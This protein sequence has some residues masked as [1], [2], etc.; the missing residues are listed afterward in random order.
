M[1]KNIID[2]LQIDD[3]LEESYNIQVAKG[4][5]AMPKGFKETYKQ[6]KREQVLKKRLKQWQ[7][8][9]Q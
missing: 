9:E 8:N 1:L 2:L 7:K 3:F 4:L 6:K 5:Y